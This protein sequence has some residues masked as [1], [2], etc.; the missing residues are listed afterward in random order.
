[1]PST[2][3]RAFLSIRPLLRPHSFSIPITKTKIKNTTPGPP[4]P[5]VKTP[6]KIRATTHH[7]ITRLPIDLTPSRQ[8]NAFLVEIAHETIRPQ[9]CPYEHSLAVRLGSLRQ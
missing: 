7:H 5:A 3:H 6:P 1:V 8:L 2:F 9:G 4:V